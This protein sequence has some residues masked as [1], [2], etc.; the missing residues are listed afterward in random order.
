MHHQKFFQSLNGA[1]VMSLA[2]GIQTW[3]T[4]LWVSVQRSPQTL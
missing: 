3:Q 1:A 2:G 4:A